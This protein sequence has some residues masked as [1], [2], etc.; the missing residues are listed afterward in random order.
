MYHL[1]HYSKYM[2]YADTVYLRVSYNSQIKKRLFHYNR[3]NRLLFV[4]VRHCVFHEARILF[5]ILI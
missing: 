4:K 5:L 3:I 2:N 1:T